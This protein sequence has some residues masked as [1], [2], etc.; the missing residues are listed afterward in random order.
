MDDAFAAADA[1]LWGFANQ[2]FAEEL[3]PLAVDFDVDSSSSDE[4]MVVLAEGGPRSMMEELFEPAIEVR[5]AALTACLRRPNQDHWAHLRDVRTRLNTLLHSSQ[6]TAT[7]YLTL[8]RALH[9]LA[10]S[11]TRCPQFA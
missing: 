8:Q 9:Q 11:S 3:Q 2:L 7:Q 4:E 1:D 10:C 6:H 5:S